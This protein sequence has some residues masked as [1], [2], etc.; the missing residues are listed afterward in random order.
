MSL[1][2]GIE[3]IILTA[4]GVLAE[5]VNEFFLAKTQKNKTKQK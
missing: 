4:I 2:S 5:G 3:A 1:E